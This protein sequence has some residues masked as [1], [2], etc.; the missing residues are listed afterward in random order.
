MHIVPQWGSRSRIAVSTLPLL[1]VAATQLH[2]PLLCHCI[3]VGRARGVCPVLHVCGCPLAQSSWRT[4]SLRVFLVK[5]TQ[6]GR[7]VLEASGIVELRIWVPSSP[8]N[9]ILQSAVV[10]ARRQ[11][12]VHLPLLIVINHFCPGSWVGLAWKDRRS[13]SG[14]RGASGAKIQALRAHRSSPSF[15]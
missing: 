11:Y 10:P 7:R 2:Q 15:P 14:G 4:L 13:R 12:C 3:I 5:S 6:L 9:L 1:P 8:L